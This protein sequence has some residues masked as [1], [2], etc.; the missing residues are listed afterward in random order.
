MARKEFEFK[1]QK[2]FIKWS[3][4]SN[5]YLKYQEFPSRPTGPF[6]STNQTILSGEQFDNNY[7]LADHN[8][9]LPIWEGGLLLKCDQQ[10]T[11]L[12]VQLRFKIKT[13]YP[14]NTA[15]HPQERKFVSPLSLL[16]WKGAFKV[17]SKG[18]TVTQSSRLHFEKL[19]GHDSKNTVG[20][21]AKTKVTKK[22]FLNLSFSRL[23]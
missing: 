5:Y 15:Y 7:P 6:S 13:K 16:W 14:N 3:S 23:Y 21:A 4:P 12:H 19:G 9:L 2:L 11:S 20:V 17:R 1:R 10:E 8:H 22:L 18:K